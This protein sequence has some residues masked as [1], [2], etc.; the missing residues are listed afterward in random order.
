MGAAEMEAF[1]AI[2]EKEKI[3][4]IGDY[5]ITQR[6]TGFSLSGCVNESLGRKFTLELMKPGKWRLT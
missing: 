1:H 4:Q 5:L 6:R 2:F 3:Y